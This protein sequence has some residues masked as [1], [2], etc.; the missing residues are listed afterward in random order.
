MI[1]CRCAAIVFKTRKPSS[2]NH[3][4]FNSHQMSALVGVPKWKSLNRPP[5]MVTRCHY[6]GEDGSLQWGPMS[7]IRTRAGGSLHCEVQCIIDNNP[8][9]QVKTLPSHNFVERPLKENYWWNFVEM[10]GILGIL[11]S[12]VF[13]PCDLWK[14]PPTIMKSGKGTTCDDMIVISK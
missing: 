5:V 12:A 13:L 10:F 8:S 7:S 3:R 14:L 1:V 4:C 2:A 9:P 11:D 6:Q